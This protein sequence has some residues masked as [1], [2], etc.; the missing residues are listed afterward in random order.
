MKL[1]P[2]GVH[3]VSALSA[4]IE[5]THDFYTRVLGLRPLIKSVNQDDPSMYRLYYG[6]GAGSAGSAMTVFDLPHAAPERR[7]NNSVARTTFRVDGE[8]A[9][10]YWAARLQE[11]GFTHN[12][13]AQRDGRL[14]LDFDDPEGTQLSLVDD[15]GAGMAFPWGDSPVPAPFQIRGLDYTMINV[16]VLGPTDHFLTEGLGLRHDRTY[17]LVDAPQYQVHVYAMREA[18]AHT[19]VH[20]V[21][22]DDLPRAR[23]GA[24]GV[25]H[26]ALRVV[27]EQSLTDWSGQLHALGY[28]NSGVVDRHYFTS[29]YVREPN[30]VLFE[31]ASDGPGFDVDGALGV[32]RLSLPPFLEPRR[33]E[34]EARL[35]PLHIANTFGTSS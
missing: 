2:T 6:D 21:V 29:L 9:L 32:E 33:A 20:V 26:V 7:G 27:A 24:G 11:H 34:I 10:S 19:E 31:L 3:H 14:A 16:P 28:H 35:K 30:G 12:E 13:I 1:Q 5:Q 22:R 17:P 18:G 23:Y 15:H 25:H 8:R 4:H